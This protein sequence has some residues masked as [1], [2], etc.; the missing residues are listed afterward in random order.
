MEKDHT[1]FARTAGIFSFFHLFLSSSFNW[2][3]WSDLFFIKDKAGYIFMYFDSHE[4]L[5]GL[6]EVRKHC[7]FHWFSSEQW[8]YRI[9]LTLS[10]KLYIWSKTGF[11]GGKEKN[12]RMNLENKADTAE[13]NTARTHKTIQSYVNSLCWNASLQEP[14]LLVAVT[15][16]GSVEEAKSLVWGISKGPERD[17]WKKREGH[18]WEM[19][20]ENYSRVE[21]CS[22]S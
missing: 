21:A 3:S 4:E 12:K 10:F 15:V 8:K 16:G 1:D 13:T 11:W 9:T 19:S 5:E 6:G 7:W 22:A 14:I 18:Q 20:S 2:K 17:G